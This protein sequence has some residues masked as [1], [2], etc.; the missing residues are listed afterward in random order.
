MVF[1]TEVTRRSLGRPQPAPG[2]LDTKTAGRRGPP[3]SPRSWSAPWAAQPA[4]RSPTSKGLDDFN[5][6]AVHSARVGPHR[7]LRRQAGRRHRH[8]RQRPAVRARRRRHR[9]AGH[10]LPAQSAPWL[11]PTPG[12][13]PG[14]RRRRALAAEQPEPVTAPTTASPSSCLGLIGNLA[15]GHGRPGLPAD[16]GLGLRGQ[17]GLRVDADRTTSW[18]RPAADE[19]LVR[20][21]VPNY[22]PAAKRIMLRRR[23][24]GGDPEAGRRRPRQRQG[25]DRVDADGV[26]TE[27]GDHV[28]AD[29]ILFGT[30]FK[31][32]DFLTPMRV[33]GVHGK[34][35]HETW[36]IDACAY[37]G[38]TL[39]GL[40]ELLLP[41]RPEH[42]PRAARQPRLL[43]RVPVGLRPQRHQG[44]A[45]HGASRRCPFAPR[46]STSTATR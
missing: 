32:S 39:P 25:R 37:M 17:R 29:V 19:E 45:R 38:L 3:S 42:Q 44:A 15:G 14:H 27:S 31:A 30:G 36:G 21:I 11:V 7:R 5:G 9:G 20:Q 34:D 40:P 13:A 26:W 8:R 35:L 22:P 1:G 12:A 18:S 33:T 10:H 6:P 16:R 43:P 4:P 2:R 41:L 28:E 23:H 24:V 46:C